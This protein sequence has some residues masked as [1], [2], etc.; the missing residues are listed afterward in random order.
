MHH[1]P[2]LFVQSVGGDLALPTG[3]CE[4]KTEVDGKLLRGLK[5]N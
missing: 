1:L 4:E 2:P 5:L 3:V